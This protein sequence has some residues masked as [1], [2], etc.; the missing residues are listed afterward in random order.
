[1][2]RRDAANLAKEVVDSNFINLIQIAESEGELISPSLFLCIFSNI[3]FLF[4]LLLVLSHN[5]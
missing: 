1:M 3:T 5:N 2:Y 4:G